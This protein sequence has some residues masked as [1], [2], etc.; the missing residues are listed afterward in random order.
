M[1]DVKW[2]FYFYNSIICFMSHNSGS[3]NGVHVC[4]IGNFGHLN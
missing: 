3:Q 2:A 4:N 1:G